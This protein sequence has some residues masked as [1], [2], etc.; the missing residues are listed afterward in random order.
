VALDKPQP[1]FDPQQQAIKLQAIHGL[2]EGVNRS[3]M[4]P[5][6]KAKTRARLQAEAARIIASQERRKKRIPG[7]I[8]TM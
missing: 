8:G 2:I 4:A 3:E 6:E 5:A 1:N 7:D